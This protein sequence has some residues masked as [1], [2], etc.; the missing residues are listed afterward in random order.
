MSV[1]EQLARQWVP[2]AGGSC[3]VRMGHDA[4]MQASSVFSGCVGRPRV[5]LAI[6]RASIDETIQET[7]RRQLVD[8]GF[9]VTWLTLEDGVSNTLEAASTVAAALADAGVTSDDLCCV[10][11][12]ANLISVAS[13][14][15]G[16]WCGGMSLVAIP[17][18]ELALLEGAIVPRSLDVGWREGVMDVRP[19]AQHVLLDFDFV[20]SDRSSETAHYLRSMMVATAMAGSEREFS[21]LWDRADLLARGEE[22]AMQT[23][24][25]AVARA[26]GQL[27]SSTAAAVR[28][29]ADY[30]RSFERAVSR[31]LDNDAPR[32]VLLAE[33]MRFAARIAVALGKFS[34]DDMLAQDELLDSL[35][36]GLA[37]CSFEAQELCRA[38]K[39]EEF[40]RRNRFMLLVPFS[41]GQVRFVTV[42]DD[43]LAEHAGAWC[44]ARSINA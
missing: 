26:R 3:D 35:G 37:E 44:D 4:L 31:L 23:Q 6:V 34:I 24:L 39:Q 33:G 28:Q 17:A 38:L 19:A 2:M 25:L 20:F 21:E 42:D 14:A 30:G 18:D 13:Y 1:G 22:E 11:G 15:C 9:S 12:D 41:I 16:S 43:M 40:A 29:S 7:L 5:C 36:I 8:A 10:L 32:S 27:K